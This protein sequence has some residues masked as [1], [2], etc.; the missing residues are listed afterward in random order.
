ML[1]FGEAM[2]SLNAL[3]IR[4]SHVVDGYYSDN[5]SRRT[6]NRNSIEQTF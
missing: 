5:R 4:L 3:D 6:D 2:R 1:G